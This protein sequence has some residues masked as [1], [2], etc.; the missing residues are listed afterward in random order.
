MRA[1][2]PL[3]GVGSARLIEA[4]IAALAGFA[5]NGAGASSVAAQGTLDLEEAEEL[6][7]EVIR[8]LHIA[9]LDDTDAFGVPIALPDGNEETA[10]D[11]ARGHLAVILLAARGRIRLATL[12][13]ITGAELGALS[14]YSANWIG[15]AMMEGAVPI[16]ARPASEDYPVGS[17]GVVLERAW[18]SKSKK[19][20][21]PIAGVGAR[22][23]LILLG[24]PGFQA[25]RR[26]GR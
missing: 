9:A 2:G 6:L 13:E 8:W 18:V 17:V 12:N 24:V 10:A 15:K 21:A 14:G 5:M 26:A 1:A 25:K 3:A 7:L 22:E 20:A 16:G 19:F 11:G 23:L 4:K